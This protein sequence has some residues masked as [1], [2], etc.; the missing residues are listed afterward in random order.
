[1]T[2]EDNDSDTDTI[3]DVGP[4]SPAT[5][6]DA[7]PSAEEGKAGELDQDGS[8]NGDD[9]SDDDESDDDDNTV[10]FVP[11]SRLPPVW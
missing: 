6:Q 9:D 8:S 5:S 7:A 11:N 2:S 4:P 3:T 1:V 10:I